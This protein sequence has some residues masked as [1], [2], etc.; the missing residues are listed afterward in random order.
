MA[1]RWIQVREG[2]AAVEAVQRAVGAEEGLLHDVLGGGAVGGDAV[3][4]VEDHASMTVHQRS[5]GVLVPRGS[6]AHQLQL[7]VALLH[8]LH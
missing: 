5:E 8:P 7:Q 6:P 4:E 1:M 3:S 2:G